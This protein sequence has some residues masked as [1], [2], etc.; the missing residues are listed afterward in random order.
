MTSSLKSE[1]AA[2]QCPISRVT[3]HVV[4]GPDFHFSGYCVNQALAESSEQHGTKE[5]HLP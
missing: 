3:V 4:F 5:L 2:P 1:N